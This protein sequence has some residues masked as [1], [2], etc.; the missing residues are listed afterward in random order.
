MFIVKLANIRNISELSKI[1]HKKNTRMLGG[2]LR[3][4]M[5]LLLTI[6]ISNI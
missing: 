5:G 4:K 2:A 3:A 6:P 1:T